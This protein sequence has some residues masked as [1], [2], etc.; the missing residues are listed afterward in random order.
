MGIFKNEYKEAFEL[1]L[2]ENQRLKRLLQESEVRE[3][4][5]DTSAISVLKLYGVEAVNM[6]KRKVQQ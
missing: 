3:R 6:Y 4:I 1:S 5:Y 2:K